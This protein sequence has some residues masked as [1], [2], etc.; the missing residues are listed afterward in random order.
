[1]CG[2]AQ[3]RKVASVGGG[4]WRRIIAPV[5]VV[6][7]LAVAAPGA[8]AVPLTTTPDPLPGSGFQGADGDQA[9]APPLSDWN[10]L[11]GA[12]KVQH[13]PDPNAQD[14]AFDGGSKENAPGEWDIVEEAGGVKPSQAN[15]LDAWSS[16]DTPASDTFLYLSFARAAGSGTSFLTFELNR[17]GRLWD[18]GRA[19]VPCRR[20]GDLLITFQPHGNDVTAIVETWE[21][22]AT[23][24][25]TG[26]AR[27]GS[28]SG[29][30]GV[31]ANVDVQGAVNA[32]PIANSLPGSSGPTIPTAQ[33]GE[34]AID[35]AAVLDAAGKRCGAF[36][37][38]WMHS[39]S[40]DSDSANMQ[41]FVAPQ[42][43]DARRCS[44]A[45]TKWLDNDADGIRD[46]GD[47]GLA[48]FRIYADLNDNE[49][50]DD[51]EPF[52]ISDERGDWVI[53]GI[54]SE[55][56]YTLCEKPTRDAP[57][58]RWR[59]SH[60]APDCW[61]TVDA[62][63]EPYARDRDFGNWIPARVTLVKQLDPPDDPGRFD[64]SV[65]DKALA[66]A[67]D[68]DRRTFRVRPGT[69]PVVE[70]PAAGTDGSLYDSS[71][72]CG[73]SS[74][75]AA[76]VTGP[77]TTVSVT[78]GERVTC[79]FVN[80]RR[81][82]PSVTI[83][84]VAPLTALHGET[85][86]YELTVTNTGT[87]AFAE[88][89]VEV[90][91]GRCDA[92]PVLSGKADAG[93]APDPTPGSFDPGDVWTYGCDRATPAP[94]DP[95]DCVP[96][97]LDNTGHVAVP[98]SGDSDSAGTVLRSQPPRTPDIEIQKVGPGTAVAGNPLVYTLYVTNI[99]EVPFDEADVVVTDPDC[100]A[101]PEL[102][103]RFDG[104]GD[105]DGS[106]EVLDP[107]D[108]WAYRCT[109][110]TP[111]PGPDC[112]ES[113]VT[114]TATVVA[115]GRRRAVDDSD[116]ADTV[117]TCPPGP[118]PD[119]VTPPEPPVD[120]EGNVPAPP[121]SPPPPDAG[122]AGVSDLKPLRRCVRRG[123]RVVIRGSRIASV[124]VF[125]GGRRVGGLEVRALQRRAIVRVKRDLT[126]GRYRVTAV[127][128]FQR[129]AA[130]PP[131]RLKR[132]VRVCA[133]RAPRFTG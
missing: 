81:G 98:G 105:P 4:S 76:R 127:V 20:T 56:T 52:A 69:Y 11:Q 37:S 115:T 67:G 10:G 117:L 126:P 26:C 49:A 80:V 31:T 35:L 43:I 54:A 61:W 87:I 106:P 121:P 123:T 53:D 70:T 65:G 60:P 77:T 94:D 88:A 132:T 5:L 39:R 22:G 15:I 45:G 112:T 91:D 125:T 23:D 109:N 30:A 33:F 86:H 24:P 120:P 46:P 21:T 44:A 108:V 27:T 72:T 97:V 78:A 107:E 93:G 16:V 63:E 90:T 100:N 32:G 95:D 74:R 51:G 130:T 18:N 116:S 110:T 73:P 71:V 66:G 12:G 1:M 129:G 92:P 99:G 38:M 19:R 102:I 85:I 96:E 42:G 9:D 59:C 34:T 48:G 113:V 13:A 83:R 101:P 50:Y 6:A 89:D 131:V 84:K 25:S 62:A 75:R 3:V 57:R 128:S 36:T 68:G 104:A 133:T 103:A 28:L 40:S 122:T 7:G 111:A 82:S 47:L 118:P 55:G 29:T 14:T 2:S 17:D 79:T 124:R 58:G 114:N 64:L 119:P 8:G 41:D